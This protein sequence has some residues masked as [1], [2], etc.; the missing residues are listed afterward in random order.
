MLSNW[1]M[2]SLKERVDLINLVASSKGC[3]ELAKEFKIENLK[4]GTFK[5]AKQTFWKNLNRTFKKF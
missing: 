2:L 4:P 1:K 3:C 5:N